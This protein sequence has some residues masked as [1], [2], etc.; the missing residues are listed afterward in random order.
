MSTSRILRYTAENVKRISF[1]EFDP[2]TNMVVVSGANAE[3]KSSVIDAIWL[4]LG[5]PTAARSVVDPIHHGRDEAYVRLDLGDIIVDRRWR[6][7][8]DGTVKTD[9]LVTDPDGAAVR[10]PAERV[11][12]LVGRFSLDPL[13]F[14]HRPPADQVTT[15]LSVIEFP[16]RED[17]TRFEPRVAEAQV[18]QLREE[19]KITRAERDAMRA[20]VD[21]MVEPPPGT[22]EAPLSAA[23]LV[24]E[25][26][27]A[28]QH[29]ARIARFAT[30]AEVAQFDVEGER[31][32]E[33]NLLAE[34]AQCRARIVE[35]ETAADA[36]RAAH[37]A[38]PDPIDMDQFDA[39]LAAIDDINRDVGH[40]IARRQAVTA[41][42]Q[43]ET[44][45]D[46]IESELAAVT[47]E[48]EEALAAA[49]LPIRGLSFDEDGVRYNGVAL[50]D[51]A[52]SEQIRIGVSIAM[53]LNPTLRVI[54]IMDGSLLDSAGM[55]VVRQMAVDR[56]YQVWIEV[57]DDTGDLG[58]VIEDG[59]IR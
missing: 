23:D 21:G 50:K 1:V 19:R 56:D 28:G 47:T 58:I 43:L 45:F 40:G 8:P 59:G 11:A 17:G 48:K 46:G 32:R 16:E 51:C 41:L 57:V 9:L 36:A 53:A 14:V 27:A 6:R 13:D 39:R 3:G 24:A 35:L 4:A 49:D 26:D 55:E 25:R 18:H 29:N 37:A 33:Q 42:A 5:G 10:K 30:T 52:S 2:D 38:A 34:L 15:L 7:M 12:A 20:R 44:R 54:R 22:P 31:N